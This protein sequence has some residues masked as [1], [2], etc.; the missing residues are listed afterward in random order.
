MG[1]ADLCANGQGNCGNR[2]AVYAVS[3]DAGPV[4]EYVGCFRDNEGGR[5]LIGNGGAITGVSEVP[6]AAANDCAAV[7]A[8]YQYFGLQWRNECFCDNSY[9]NG[10]GNNGN[11]ANCPGGECPATD[12]D[13]DGA[14]D[15]DGTMSRARTASPTAATATPCTVSARAS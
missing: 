1:T 4:F 13:T 11:Q 7:C 5:D 3:P 6:L 12:C 14:L 9:N 2:N 8:G 10:Y 15:D